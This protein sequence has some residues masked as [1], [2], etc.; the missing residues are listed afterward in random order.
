[1]SFLARSSAAF[2]GFM[3][4]PY[5]MRTVSAVSAPTSFASVARMSA[6]TSCAWSGVAVRPV[7]MAQTG[8]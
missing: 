8:S 4:P 5:W 1:M 6:W 7:P 3:D 2:P